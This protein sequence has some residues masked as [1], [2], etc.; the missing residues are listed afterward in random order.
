VQRELTGRLVPL[1]NNNVG[2]LKTAATSSSARPTGEPAGFD[3][4]DLT[5]GV[6]YASDQSVSHHCLSAGKSWECLSTVIMPDG[7]MTLHGP[8][9][10]QG[11]SVFSVTGAQR[12]CSRFGIP[13]IA[14]PICTTCNVNDG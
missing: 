7:Q 13:S 12:D 5:N 8:W 4:D 1:K 2:Q 10:D 11:T 6:T 9:L 3:R 14:R